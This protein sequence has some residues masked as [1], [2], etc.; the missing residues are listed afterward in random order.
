V[1]VSVSKYRLDWRGTQVK[2]EVR[3]NVAEA[4]GEVGLHVE[5]AGKKQLSKG[6]GVRSGTLRR[7]IHSAAPGYNWQGDNVPPSEGSPE[8]GGQLALAGMGSD[9]VTIQVGSGLVYAL[10]V[11]QGFEDGSFEGYHYLTIGLDEVKPQIPGIMKAHG[12]GVRR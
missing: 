3:K 8:R 12:V 1:A 2:G 4:W 11:H 5:T 10:A 7:S 9:G 6:H